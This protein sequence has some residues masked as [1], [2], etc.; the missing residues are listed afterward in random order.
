MLQS[1][2]SG[3]LGISKYEVVL[4]PGSFTW[5]TSDRRCVL[6]ARSGNC[7]MCGKCKTSRCLNV[8]TN[9]TRFNDSS[10]KQCTWVTLASRLPKAWTESILYKTPKICRML[11]TGQDH[12]PWASRWYQDEHTDSMPSNVWASK[13]GLIN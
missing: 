13:N 4:G 12:P 7:L 9:E 8:S 11:S 3:R 5:S 6:D 2:K 10:T 1:A